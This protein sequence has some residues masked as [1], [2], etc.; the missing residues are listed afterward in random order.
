MIDAS[1]AVRVALD[2]ETHASMVD[3]LLSAEAI[4]APSIFVVETANALC[5]YVRGKLLSEADALAIHRSAVLLL[6]RSI[7]STELFPEA[8]MLAS[9]WQHPVHDVLYLITARRTSSTLLTLDTVLA[10]LAG[11]L[12]IAVVTN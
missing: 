8:L 3:R 6:D 12:D 1:V 4:Y 5:K 10:E 7:D 2:H 9:Q 11:R